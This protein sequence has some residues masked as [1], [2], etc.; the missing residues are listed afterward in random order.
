M[1]ANH[2][3]HLHTVI[4]GAA[5]SVDTKTKQ[6]KYKKREIFNIILNICLSNI[7]YLKTNGR[8]KQQ[9]MHLQKEQFLELTVHIANHYW[10][11]F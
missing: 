1:T 2:F 10:L 11:Y 5:S 3:P 6:G 7:K 9:V 4:F 8:T